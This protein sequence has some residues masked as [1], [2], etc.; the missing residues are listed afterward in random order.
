[1]HP[2][3]DKKY[4]IKKSYVEK[5]FCMLLYPSRK[6]EIND[7]MEINSFVVFS[8]LLYFLEIFIFYSILMCIKMTIFFDS[9]CGKIPKLL[10][11]EKK[12]LKLGEN[13]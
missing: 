5:D 2:T 9:M 8:T 3:D 11:L 6:L 12:I 13:N 7:S 4:P 1:M 10:K